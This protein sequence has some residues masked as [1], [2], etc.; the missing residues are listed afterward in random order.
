MVPIYSVPIPPSRTVAD[1]IGMRKTRELL[2][3][4]HDLEFHL[5]HVEWR[6]GSRH[7]TEQQSTGADMAA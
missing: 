5:K 7:H 2:L 4:I 1:E 3:R 6:D